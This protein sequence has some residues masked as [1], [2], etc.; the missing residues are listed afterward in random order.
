VTTPNRS[1]QPDE[2]PIAV[3]VSE[4]SRESLV[5][6]ADRATLAAAG[7]TFLADNLNGGVKK[8]GWATEDEYVRSVISSV[9]QA[10]SGLLAVAQVLDEALVYEQRGEM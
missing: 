4:L 5:K 7:I 6:R 1:E 3:P 2:L 8:G 9:R 10:A